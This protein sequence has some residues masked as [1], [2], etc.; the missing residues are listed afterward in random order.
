GLIS[1]VLLVLPAFAQSS[2]GIGAAEA[3]ISKPGSG[4]FSSF[5][6]WIAVQQSEFYRLMTDALRELRGNPAVPWSLIGL[7]FAYGILHAAGPGHGKVVISSYMLATNT[8]LRRGVLISLGSSV[9]QAISAIV[10][11][12][13]GFMF[14]RQLSIS[15]TDTTRGFELAS[16]AL[17]TLL[18]IWLVVRSFIRLRQKPFASLSAAAVVVHDHHHDHHHGHS[19]G[20]HHHGHGE[21]CS[22]CGHVHMPS[23]SQVQRAGSFKEAVATI[24]S[25]GLRPC[26]G[27]LVVL[28]FSFMN[29]LWWAGIISAFVMSLGTAITVS[30]LAAIAVGAK[31][32]AQRYAG[33][34]TFGPA[35]ISA[36][37]IIGGLLIL[38]IGISLLG[39]ALAR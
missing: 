32:L 17:V 7:S 4:P 25:V 38:L 30:T 16:Y 5:F 36:I 14:L 35:A 37:E 23:P 27:A 8:Q 28:T 22:S 10:I 21:T 33:I 29:G 2:L 1:A 34:S 20:H 18:G 3:P 31:G 26:T 12:G 19:H 6:L 39:G 13:L 15:V 9:L 24:F 11:V